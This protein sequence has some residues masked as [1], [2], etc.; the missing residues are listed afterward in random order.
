M[1]SGAGTPGYPTAGVA[2]PG[3]YSGQGAPAAGAGMS[4]F[5]G[6]AAGGAAVGSLM[7]GLFGYMA[8]ENAQDVYRSRARMIRAEAENEAQRYTEQVGRTKATQKVAF[9][10]AGV[11]LSGSPLDILDETI[12]VGRENA[13]AIRAGGA[14]RALDSE[15][16]GE[17]AATAGRNALVSGITGAAKSAAVG[18]Y[19]IYSTKEEAKGRNTTSPTGY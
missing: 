19:S 8:G 5:A 18:A 16:G 6:G 11:Q 7:A 13:A 9:L 4:T 3:T 12:R 15:F 14:A 2:G 10:K 17:Q 1:I